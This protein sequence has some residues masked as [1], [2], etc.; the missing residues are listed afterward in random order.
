LETN[1]KTASV[2]IGLIVEGFNNKKI[3]SEA[4]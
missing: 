2:H 4:F 3:K 1:K